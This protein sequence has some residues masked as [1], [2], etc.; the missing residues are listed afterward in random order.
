M[1]HETEVF[2][3]MTNRDDGGTPDPAKAVAAS[4]PGLIFDRHDAM[5]AHRKIVKAYGPGYGVYQATLSVGPRID[6]EDELDPAGL[7]EWQRLVLEEYPARGS[8]LSRMQTVDDMAKV[9]RAGLAGED[10]HLVNLVVELNEAATPAEAAQII[11][12][13]AD[14]AYRASQGPSR[15]DQLHFETVKRVL[16]SLLDIL[17]PQDGLAI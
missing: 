1:G 12:F 5:E 2:L 4:T 8:I 14:L 16:N 6:L 13:H 9:I 11:E 17:R 7:N 10:S 3:V 15:P